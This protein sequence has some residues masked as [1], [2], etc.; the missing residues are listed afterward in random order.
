MGNCVGGFGYCTQERNTWRFGGDVCPEQYASCVTLTARTGGQNSYLTNTVDYGSCNASNVGCTRYD[1]VRGLREEGTLDPSDDAYVWST[2]VCSNSDTVNPFDACTTDTDCLGG[3]T[4]ALQASFDEEDYI[5][6]D[7][8]A[9]ACDP[10]NDGCTEL[11]SAASASLNVIANPSFEQDTFVDGQPDFWSSTGGP[12]TFDQTNGHFGNASVVFGSSSTIATMYQI[13]LP[14]AETTTFSY[15]A[16]GEASGATTSMIFSSGLAPQVLGGNCTATAGGF[17]TGSLTLQTDAWRRV[18]CTV[19]TSP[20]GRTAAPLYISGSN[21]RVDGVQVE[22]VT[23]ATDFHAGYAPGEERTHIRISSPE[24]A[25]TGAA[26]DPS[27]CTAYAPSCLAT[28]VGCSAYKPASGTPTVPGIINE[29]NLCP[30]ECVGYETYRQLET[31]FEDSEFP[32]YFIASTAT[33]CSAQ[34]AGCDEFTNLDSIAEGGERREYFSDVRAC[35]EVIEASDS[36]HPG[37][38]YYTWE[39]SDT[40]GFQLKTWS[41]KQS[42]SSVGPCVNFNAAI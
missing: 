39:G 29:T 21:A 6:L 42:N 9:S 41:L 11:V 16:R 32:E 17:A 35:Q 2:G 3:G 37:T 38:T 30:S 10:S 22:Y 26:S 4:C 19:A 13:T 27:E 40:E 25:C 12:F 15:Y 8:D 14:P 1:K 28:E 5:F 33:S 23:A 7:A 24:I 34:Y 20:F 36:G 31:N 18:T